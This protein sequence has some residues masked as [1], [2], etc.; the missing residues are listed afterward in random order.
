[1]HTSAQPRVSGGALASTRWRFA[2]V[3]SPRR[4]ARR[5][6]VYSGRHEADATDRARARRGRVARPAWFRLLA[7]AAR[8]HGPRHAARRHR[9]RPRRHRAHRS[10]AQR[11]SPRAGR[12]PLR[13]RLGGARS[14]RAAHPARAHHRRGRHH[15]HGLHLHDPHPAHRRP[16]LRAHLARGR[17]AARGVLTVSRAVLA[18]VR[19]R[20]A[21]RAAGARLRARHGA[22][23]PHP[24]RR[25]GCRR[26]ARPR[27][28]R[29]PHRARAH[30]AGLRGPR[31]HSRR[32]VAPAAGLARSR[33]RLRRRHPAVLLHPR[34]GDRR[35]ARG[36]RGRDEPRAVGARPSVLDRAVLDSAALDSAALEHDAGAPPP[37][38]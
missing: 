27:A 12:H 23:R 13:R 36:C 26:R 4:T 2:G 16:V 29:P 38:A 30:D 14:R 24:R 11:R 1:M 20:P 25:I 8:S 21:A 28:R 10:R 6:A 33:A 7:A 32:P 35:H 5:H 34:R 9:G 15:R 19:R 3:S 22:R 18:L 17:A 37:P 31:H